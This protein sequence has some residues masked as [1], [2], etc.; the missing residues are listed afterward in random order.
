MNFNE[1]YSKFLKEKLVAKESP[2]GYSTG[3]QGK[4]KQES[5]KPMNTK[6]AGS[7][8]VYDKET[9]DNTDALTSKKGSAQMSKENKEPTMN[10]LLDIMSE[11]RLPNVEYIEK[12]VKGVIDK[13]TAKME[14]YMGGSWTRLNT[15]YMR[16]E[17]T[18]KMH[19]IKRDELN[20]QITDKIASETFDPADELYTRV[21]ETNDAVFTLAKAT[22]RQ[23]KPTLDAPA[24]IENLPKELQERLDFLTDD[25]LPELTKA[26]ELLTEKYTTTYEPQ[27]VK[28]ALRARRKTKFSDLGENI[29]EEDQ[30]NNFYSDKFINLFKKFFN[31]YDKEL[32]YIKNI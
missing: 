18:L 24:M 27:E 12:A 11:A 14:S 21:V 30:D 7:D 16:L 32:N 28:P 19:Q 17:K 29:T 25:M 5:P 13:V 20:K 3:L 2:I 4:S 8:V 10:E 15:R 23:K 9:D 31:Q 22:M 1:Y 6:K 26:I